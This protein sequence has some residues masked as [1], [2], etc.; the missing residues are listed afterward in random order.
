MKTESDDRTTLHALFPTLVYQASMEDVGAYRSAFGLIGD[1]HLFSPETPRGKRHHAGE[2][3]GK[4]L[5]HQESSLRPFFESLATHVG[6]YLQKMGMRSAVFDVNFLKSWFVICET[7]QENQ[8]KAMVPHN[9][10]CSDISWVYYVDVPAE[11]PAIQFH[12]GTRLANELFESGF[13]FDWDDQTK[14]AIS[15]LNPWNSDSYSIHPKQGDLL[16]FPG[17]QL[18]SVDA[19]LTDKRRLSVAGDI[20]LTLKPQYRNLEF[21][22]TAAKHWLTLPM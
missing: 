10:S 4:I 12:V 3:H 16:I 21:G 20:A 22:R 7:E 14:S 5:L 15:T 8:P 1:S 9:H 13:H 11:C 17:R 18:H 6:R 19:N 2:Y